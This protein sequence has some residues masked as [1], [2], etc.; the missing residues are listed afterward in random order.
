MNMLVIN[1]HSFVDLITNSSTEIYTSAHGRTIDM[2]K[3]LVDKVLQAGGSAVTAD[4]LFNFSLTITGWDE[5]EGREVTVDV[6]T[7]KGKEIQKN[8]EQP[9]LDLVVTAKDPVNKAAANAL[10]SISKMFE[11][12]EKYC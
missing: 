6:S 2:A 10:K 11:T 5:E 4:D 9:T 8:N 12:G 7:P 1:V 3:D